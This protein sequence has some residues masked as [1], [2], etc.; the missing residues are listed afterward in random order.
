MAEE[1]IKWRVH[2]VLPRTRS[3]SFAATSL[4]VQDQARLKLG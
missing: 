3:A 4:A 2:A 1:I